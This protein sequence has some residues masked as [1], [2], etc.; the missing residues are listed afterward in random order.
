METSLMVDDY[1]TEPEYEEVERDL[2]EEANIYA[3]EWYEMYREGL[4]EEE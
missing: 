1:P 2:E 3:N 4:L